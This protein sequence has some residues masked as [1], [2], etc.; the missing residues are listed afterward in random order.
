MVF[1][2]KKTRRKARIEIIPMIDTM[3]FLLVF[4]MLSSL[5]LTRLDGLPVDL[6]EAATAP[7]AAPAPIT[8]TIDRQQRIFV[9]QRQVALADLGPA[10]LRQGGESSS[11]T[12]G[13]D[14]SVIV[15]ADRTVAH[16]LVVECLDRA[17]AVEI[18]RFAIATVPGT[19]QVQ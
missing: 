18:H 5:A 15:N 7:R 16:G 13:R 4:F 1:R 3:F 12:P 8:L 19:S 14:L 2:G 6:P 10:L 9:N 17:R 11:T